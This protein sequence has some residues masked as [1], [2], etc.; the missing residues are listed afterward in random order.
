MSEP[1]LHPFLVWGWR[2]ALPILI[3]YVVLL[4]FVYLSQLNLVFPGHA[5]QRD[6]YFHVTPP[7]DAEL[8][9]LRTPGGD[10][11]AALFGPALTPEGRPHPQARR[12]PTLLFF[13]GNG[14]SLKG[15][16]DQ[17]HEFRRLGVNVM[18][19]EY[20]GYGMSEGSAS[21]SG[22]YAT[23]DAAYDHLLTRKDIDPAKIVSAGWSLGGAVA[24]DL[25][26]RRP[27]AGLAAFST[28]TSLADMGRRLYPVFPVGLLVRHKFESEEKIA[29]VA[30]PILLGHGSRDGMIPPSMMDRL[31]GKAGGPVTTFLVEGAGHNDFFALGAEQIDRELKRLIDRVT[32]EPC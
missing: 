14:D 20:L 16:Q 22:C 5:S 18:I 17:F 28:F 32:E 19:P 15:N 10:T 4:L 11:V 29:K 25:A 23:A 13:Y 27:V 9:R 2:I 24:I 3:V 30:C 26:A 6:S 8:L 12:R 31:A 21:E 7:P 1:K